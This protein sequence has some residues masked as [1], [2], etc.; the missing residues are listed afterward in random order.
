MMINLHHLCRLIV[1]VH[2]L[3]ELVAE[4]VFCDFKIIVC[5]H[6]H[7]ALGINAEELSKPQSSISG[8]STLAGYYFTDAPLW[9][10]Y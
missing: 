6:V 5:L 7:P 8:D 3:F 10:T 1:R 4:F 2:I 9:H